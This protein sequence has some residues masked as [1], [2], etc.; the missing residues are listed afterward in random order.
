MNKETIELIK[1]IEKLEEKT[2]EIKLTDWILQE[3][4]AKHLEWGKTSEVEMNWQEAKDW[5]E[6]QGGRLPTIVELM[7]AYHGKIGGFKDD[8]Y[9]SSSESSATGP[10]FLGFDG[11]SVSTYFAKSNAYYVRCVRGYLV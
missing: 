7:E 6:K 8:F 1:R 5:C 2:K 11:G 10:F 9:W 4:P 3:I